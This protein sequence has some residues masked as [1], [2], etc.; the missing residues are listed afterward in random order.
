[1]K[2]LLALLILTLLVTPASALVRL[3]YSWSPPTIGTAVEYYTCETRWFGGDWSS[4]SGT[5][6]DTML[7]IETFDGVLDFQLRVAGVD[8]IGRQGTWSEASNSYNDH[9]APGP[10]GKPNLINIV[11][12]GED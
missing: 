4:C 5:A 6:S 10:P 2:Y 11:H 12:I 3:T 8:S 1:M 9:G 7:T